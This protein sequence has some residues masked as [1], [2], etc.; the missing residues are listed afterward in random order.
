MKDKPQLKKTIGFFVATSIVIGSLIESGIFMKPGIILSSAGNS[1]MAMLAWVIGGVITLAGGLTIAEVSVKIPR[2]GGLYAYLETVYGKVWDF[3]CGWNQ[4]LIYGP[5][6]IGA[7]GMYFGSIL[8]NFFGSVQNNKVWIG[9][10]T[11][12]FLTTMNLL[13]TKFGGF[14]QIMFIVGKLIPIFM[15]AFFGL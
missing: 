10:L 12:L 5:A 13:G 8:A 4:S 2:T 3:L 15:I 6:V 9:I 11:V 7:L 14:I 1:A